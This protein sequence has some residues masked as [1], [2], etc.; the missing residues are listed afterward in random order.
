MS[1]EIFTGTLTVGSKQEVN[2]YLDNQEYFPIE[3][4]EIKEGKSGS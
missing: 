2:V 1:G 4:K 3:I